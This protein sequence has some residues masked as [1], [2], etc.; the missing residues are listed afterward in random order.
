M[1]LYIFSYGSILSNVGLL[2]HTWTISNN[3]MCVN[4]TESENKSTRVIEVVIQL[5]I[6]IGSSVMSLIKLSS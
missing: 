3:D 6:S 2:T 4:C 1:S 5:F